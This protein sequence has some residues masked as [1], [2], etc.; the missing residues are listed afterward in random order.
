VRV[1]GRRSCRRCEVGREAHHP[2]AGP[3]TNRSGAGAPP[4]MGQRSQGRRSRRGAEHAGSAEGRLTLQNLHRLPRGIGIVRASRGPGVARQVLGK[5]LWA[6]SSEN[7]HAVRCKK[8]GPTGSTRSLH[9]LRRVGGFAGRRRET[10]PPSGGVLP[11][12]RAA[13]E[14][15]R[16]A[17]RRCV[18]RQHPRMLA[19]PPKPACAVKRALPGRHE[20]GG[21]G[22]SRDNR[23]S[24]LKT[25]SWIAD[26]DRY[27]SWSLPGAE[28]SGSPQT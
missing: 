18:G 4:R 12:A 9:P 8:P 26:I 21:H 7:V 25:E 27:G 5:A 13:T 22:V 14:C 3:G 11:G 19:S 15:Q 28:R 20:S 1:P 6:Q 10:S 23:Q 2:R 16:Y 17:R 24:S